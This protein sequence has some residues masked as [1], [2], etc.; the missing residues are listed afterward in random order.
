MCLR[1]LTDDDGKKFHI[2]SSGC[3]DLPVGRSAPIRE[4][5]W[6]QKVFGRCVEYS[7]R[8]NNLRPS[9]AQTHRKSKG[10]LAE[11]LYLLQWLDFRKK[12]AS[13]AGLTRHILTCHVIYL[14]VMSYTYLSRHILTSHIIYLLV[15][16]Y[17][18][19][20]HH[21]LTCHIIYLLVTSYTYLS[22]H[23]LTCH[24]VYVLV[25]SYTY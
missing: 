23:I 3:F 4:L 7:F 2:W 17:A 10:F 8:P 9:G 6:L 15:T 20:S 11:P 24:V 5:P 19:L 22:R 1:L 12:D 14:F 21:I 16:S 18:Y 25:T 13:V